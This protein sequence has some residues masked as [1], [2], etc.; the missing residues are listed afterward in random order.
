MACPCQGLHAGFAFAGKL[1]KGEDGSIAED[2]KKDVEKANGEAAWAL[3]SGAMARM[4]HGSTRMSKASPFSYLETFLSNV[5]VI[6]HLLVSSGTTIE[7]AP[8]MPDDQLWMLRRSQEDSH[9]SVSPPVFEIYISC[10]IQ[11]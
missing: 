6:S 1:A 3:V 7:K 2:A 10:S 4:V 8:V 11:I 5:T 9:S